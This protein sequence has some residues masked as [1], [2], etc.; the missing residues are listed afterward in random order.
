[1]IPKI[2]HYCWF[3]N[4]KK[5]KKVRKFIDNWKKILSDYEFIEWNETNFHIDSFAYTKE[6]YNAKKYAFVSDY[7][8]LFALFNF[9]GIYLDTDVEVIKTFDNFLNLKCF[10]SFESNQSVCTAVIGAEKNSS[11][12][13]FILDSYNDKH[14]FENGK[15][16]EFPNSQLIFNLLKTKI[17]NTKTLN[18]LDKN[19][20]LELDDVV[21][22]PLPY[23]CGKD[24]KTY[25]LCI[26]EKTVSI[27]HLDASW[28]SPKRK[29]LKFIKGILIKLG[30]KRLRKNK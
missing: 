10:M 14:F 16:D 5:P 20:I 26:N 9:G 21:I 29:V 7:V 17:T 28:Y 24:Y 12:I 30:L 1:M 8:R 25:D 23:F 22:F 6:A 27:H 15:T 18:N 11:F 4:N 2:I 19:K 3:G 13:K